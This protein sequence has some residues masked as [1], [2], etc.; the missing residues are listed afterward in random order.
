MIIISATLRSLKAYFN[1][2]YNVPIKSCGRFLDWVS[3]SL[4]IMKLITINLLNTKNKLYFTIPLSFICSVCPS[5][6][7]YI[8]ILGT[9]IL[10][11]EP[12][13]GF[14]YT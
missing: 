12:L 2:D 1:Y 13:Y 11:I 6:I 5:I 14:Y 9:I 10:S 4:S 8:L 7:Q 3:L